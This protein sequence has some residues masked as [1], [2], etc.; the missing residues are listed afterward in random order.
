MKYTQEKWREYLPSSGEQMS[1]AIDGAAIIEIDDEGMN[2]Y[3][4]IHFPN[5]KSLVI[6]YDYVYEW[7]VIDTPSSAH[8]SPPSPLD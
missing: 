2:D 4:L 1:S 8:D 3:L 5:G 6:R 7:A